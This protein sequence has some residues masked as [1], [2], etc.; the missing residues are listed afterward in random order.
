MNSTADAALAGSAA[1]SFFTAVWS[2]LTWPIC[3]MYSA[4]AIVMSNRLVG[5]PPGNTWNSP[6][7]DVKG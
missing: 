1:P 7:W 6:S 2:V 3:C 4:D 5:V